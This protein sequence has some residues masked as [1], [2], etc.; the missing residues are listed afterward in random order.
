MVFH[1]NLTFTDH[2][3]SDSQIEVIPAMVS[4]TPKPVND[5]RP[6]LANE[7][8][9]KKILDLVQKHSKN[10]TINAWHFLIPKDLL[11]YLINNI[12]TTKFWSVY[13]MNITNRI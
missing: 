7:T 10:V 5:Y 6:R 4:S 3:L 12:I 8:E 11:N 9:R 1:T 2:K 13:I